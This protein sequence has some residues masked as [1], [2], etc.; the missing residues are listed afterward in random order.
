MF[1]PNR[2]GTAR[3]R[4]KGTAQHQCLSSPR[5]CL[6]PAPIPPLATPPVQPSA[7]CSQGTAPSPHPLKHQLPTNAAPGQWTRHCSQPTDSL[8]P[9][10]QSLRAQAA[11]TGDA[12]TQDHSFKTVWAVSPHS[13]RSQNQKS[14]KTMRQRNTFPKPSETEISNLHGKEFKKQS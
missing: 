6:Q 8:Q 9:A 3:A 10:C 5:T 2:E 14:N 7:Q 13:P 11:Y 1:L 12:P 4:V